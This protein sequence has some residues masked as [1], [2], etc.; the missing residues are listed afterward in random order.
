[1]TAVYRRILETARLAD[2]LVLGHL[3]VD[4]TFTDRPTIAVKLAVWRPGVKRSCGAG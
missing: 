2:D 1:M 4:F 3:D